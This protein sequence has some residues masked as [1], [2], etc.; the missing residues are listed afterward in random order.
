MNKICTIETV[1]DFFSKLGMKP[2]KHLVE[3]NILSVN[4]VFVRLTKIM[5]NL[6]KDC[7]IL[8]FL[9]IF[10][11]LKLIDSPFFAKNLRLELQLYF[12]F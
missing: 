12:D 7:I 10:Q 9:V 5:N 2:R 1:K 8:T 3:I 11:P 6:V 4:H